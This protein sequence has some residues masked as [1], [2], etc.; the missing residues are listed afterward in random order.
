[1]R[2][3]WRAATAAASPAR[4]VA[5]APSSRH[6]EAS[7]RHQ[8]RHRVPGP[9]QQAL[10]GGQDE[11][12]APP[13]VEARPA[14]CARARQPEP[15]PLGRVG[16]QPRDGVGQ[17]ARIAGRDQQAGDAVVDGLRGSPGC[18]WRRREPPWR[19][20]PSATAGSPRGARRAR[21]C[22]CRRRGAR[23]RRG[24]PGTARR[25]ARRAC[26]SAAVRPSALSG[27]SGPTTA[28]AEPGEERSQPG[29]GLED[30][31]VALLADQPADQPDDHVVVGDRTELPPGRRPV[32]GRDRAP[33]RTVRGRCRC[34]AP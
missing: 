20:P 23:R 19:P 3:A 34:R 24:R 16:G 25:P 10:V 18:R 29:G 27:S 14:P 12:D 4:P 31:R 33:G 6:R 21:G 15:S 9:G 22:P 5:A 30:L 8:C 17:S 7:W 26:R 13:L 32:V 28:N 1:M 11:V 2:S